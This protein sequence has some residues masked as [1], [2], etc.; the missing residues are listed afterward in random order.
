MMRH[1]W[2]FLISSL[3]IAPLVVFEG[4]GGVENFL[5]PVAGNVKH[6]II[7]NTA[8]EV[9][10][11]TTLVRLREGITNSIRW[12]ASSFGRPIL[13]IPYRPNSKTASTM[14]VKERRKGERIVRINCHVRPIQFGSESY[15][16]ELKVDYQVPWQNW[17]DV[18][19]R[20][21]PIVVPRIPEKEK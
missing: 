8:K 15:K 17:W 1:V 14:L 21:P 3:I 7:K 16:L 13:V 12:T 10:V 19:R 20:D 4:P 9:C 6:E 11:R 5:A 2:G 18:T